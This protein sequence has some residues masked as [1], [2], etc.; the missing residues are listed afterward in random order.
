MKNSA[1]SEESVVSKVS[2]LMETLDHIKRY[3]ALARSLKQFALI[4]IGSIAVFLSIGIALALTKFEYSVTR[5]I[6]FVY[7]FLFLLIPLVGLALGVDY[8]TKK[9]SAT[10]TGEWREKLSGGFPSALEMLVE[11]DWD[12]VLDEISMGRLSYAL[13]SL[14]KTAAYWIVTFSGL[15]L[16]ASILS[17][18]FLHRLIFLSAFIWVVFALILVLLLL[19]KDLLR[20]YQEIHSLDMLLLELRWFSLELRRAEL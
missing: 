19:G 7:G 18:Y 2:D 20:R 11:L 12:N 8:V 15:Q 6:G 9:V 14:L 1:L 13:Y 10:K 4:V 16:I 3:N 17:L 5:P